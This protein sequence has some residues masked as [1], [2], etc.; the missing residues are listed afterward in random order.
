MHLRWILQKL[1]C[2]VIAPLVI[3]NATAES[4]YAT[5][6][7]VQILS[8]TTIYQPLMTDLFAKPRPVFVS[9]NFFWPLGWDWEEVNSCGRAMFNGR[10]E[11]SQKSLQL[12][13]DYASKI[14]REFQQYEIPMT[15]TGHDL[16][17]SI[18]ISISEHGPECLIDEKYTVAV[19]I[20]G[21]VP[22]HTETMLQYESILF[23]HIRAYAAKPEFVADTIEHNLGDQLSTI[24]PT[25]AG[26][27]QP[28]G[29][30]EQNQLDCES[31]L[32]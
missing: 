5:V 15:K 19:G 3:S 30:F 2:L 16:I 8:E 21:A 25:L 7:E 14:E 22:W 31:P 27:R 13:T 18:D 23:E 32:P 20:E 28:C 24:L 4:D 11:I 1:R 10:K 17:L 12:R 29:Y 6:S 9:F 26:L